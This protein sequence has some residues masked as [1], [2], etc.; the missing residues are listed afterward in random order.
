MWSVIM[1]FPGHTGLFV[2][3]SNSLNVIM[4]FAITNK[5]MNFN[6]FNHK[7]D[8]AIYLNLFKKFCQWE[9]NFNTHHAA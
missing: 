7:N 9:F 2:Q 6:A 4:I 8:L 5:S 1:A 3:T